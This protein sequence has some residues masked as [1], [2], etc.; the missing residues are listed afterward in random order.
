LFACFN[1]IIIVY[2]HLLL[3]G[4]KLANAEVDEVIPV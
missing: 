3:I 4:F 2:L 1:I